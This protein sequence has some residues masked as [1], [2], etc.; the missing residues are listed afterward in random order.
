MELTG[1]KTKKAVI[2]E[3]LR[4]LI[5]LKEQ[6]SIRRLRGRLHWEGNLGKMRERDKEA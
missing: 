4:T 5:R 6:E 2:E 3:A 1:L